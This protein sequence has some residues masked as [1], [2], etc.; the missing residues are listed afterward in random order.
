MYVGVRVCVWACRIRRQALPRE[1]RVDVQ[2][3]GPWQAKH[4]V[5]SL[6]W[7]FLVSRDHQFLQRNVPTCD[8]PTLACGDLEGPSLCYLTVR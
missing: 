8:S 7:H 6:V 3:C 2:V 1:L 5:G 4:P